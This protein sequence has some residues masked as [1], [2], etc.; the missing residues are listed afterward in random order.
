VKSPPVHPDV[1][2][3]AFLLGTWT[4]TGR[5]EYPSIEPFSYTETV[6]FT[7]VGKPFLAY[8]QQTKAADDGRPLHAETGFWR[9]VNERR[10]EVVLAHPT[11]IV[12]VEEGELLDG[13]LHLR[14]VGMARTGSAKEVTKVERRLTF[15]DDTLRYSLE[16]AAVG[17]PLTGHLVAELVRNG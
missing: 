5:G 14:S 9:F 8:S 3:L 11:G 4:G 17:L 15:S 7:H 13:S 16:M 1:E 2:P 10:V 6:I 12:E